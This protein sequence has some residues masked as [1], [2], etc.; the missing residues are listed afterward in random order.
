MLGL[1]GIFQADRKSAFAIAQPSN[2]GQMEDCCSPQ[3]VGIHKYKRAEQIRALDQ[4]FYGPPENAEVKR[5]RGAT[6]RYVDRVRA[7]MGIDALWKEKQR[8][9]S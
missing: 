8:W 1:V 2:A 9:R 7:A 3:P 6:R 4:Q 5:L